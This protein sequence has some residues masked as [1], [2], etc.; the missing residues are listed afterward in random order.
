M[1]SVWRAS[2]GKSVKTELDPGLQDKVKGM[3]KAVPY[4]FIWILLNSLV[5]VIV[6]IWHA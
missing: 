1:F 6:R 2:I 3:K 4:L 5:E